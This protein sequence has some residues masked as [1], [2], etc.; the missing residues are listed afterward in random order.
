MTTT[1]TDLNLPFI[2]D[3]N[4]SIA[5]K[6]SVKFELFFNG[7]KSRDLMGYD[8]FMDWLDMYGI[9]P[10]SPE[11]AQAEIGVMMNVPEGKVRWNRVA[12]IVDKPEDLL[13]DGSKGLDVGNDA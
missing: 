2:F 3:R 6:K 1:A 13:P 10:A 12:P 9:Y 8:D 5:E 4:L 7:Q 11:A